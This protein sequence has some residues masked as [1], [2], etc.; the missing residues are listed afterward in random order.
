MD[1][2]NFF[3]E[4]FD[5]PNDD[6]LL[7][8]DPSGPEESGADASPEQGPPS[9]VSDGPDEEAHARSNGAA[10]QAPEEQPS[11]PDQKDILVDQ[12]DGATT[13]LETLNDALG[14]GWKL[15]R[16]S[17]AQPDGEQAA[18]R[19]EAHRFVATLEQERPPS[20]FDFGAS[21]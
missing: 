20:L 10:E 15:V 21:A 17:L 11:P 12:R 3:G 5:D 13:G 16:I 14:E 1:D 7:G 6:P 18:S 9:W 4:V 2:D 8:D 19:R